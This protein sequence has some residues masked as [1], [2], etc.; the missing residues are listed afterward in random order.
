MKTSSYKSLAI[1]TYKH[2]DE[3]WAKYLEK[4]LQ[5]YKLPEQLLLSYTD[6]EFIER[7]RMV[8]RDSSDLNNNTIT[9]T[10][11]YELSTSKFLI[12]LCSFH[13]AHSE[14]ECKEVQCFIN[15]GREEFIIPVYINYRSPELDAS[16]CFPSLLRTLAAVRKVQCINWDIADLQ[17]VF[18]FEEIVSILYGLDAEYLKKTILEDTAFKDKTIT[19]KIGNTGETVPVF[20]IDLDAVTNTELL[21]QFAASGIVP[22]LYGKMLYTSCL[23]M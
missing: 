23:K 22:M 20:D 10:L 13:T 17:N 2:E 14:W 16:L 4:R 8:I 3:Y 9:K 1:I 11:N 6:L 12:I 15:S 19:L 5:Y 18:Q 7:P 21:S